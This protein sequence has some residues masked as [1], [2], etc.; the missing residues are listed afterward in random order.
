MGWEVV[1]FIEF[2]E[3]DTYVKRD[4]CVTMNTCVRI[5]ICVRLFFEFIFLGSMGVGS[6]FIEYGVLCRVYLVSIV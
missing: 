1:V 6:A 3:G 4:M 5:D 2:L